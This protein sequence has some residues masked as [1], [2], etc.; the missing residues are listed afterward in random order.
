M[1]VPREQLHVA[2]RP[3]HVALRAL[4]GRRQSD[5]LDRLRGWRRE[6][7]PAKPRAEPSP[8][9][10]GA[11]EPVARLPPAPFWAA[12]VCSCFRAAGPFA[13][14]LASPAQLAQAA[15]ALAQAR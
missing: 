7:Q 2:V 5:W 1:G 9:A 11:R 6:A 15:Q 12:W 13:W 4:L 3:L 8:E 14:G 10:P